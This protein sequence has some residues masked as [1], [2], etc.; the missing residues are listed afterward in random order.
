MS[1]PTGERWLTAVIPALNEEQSIESICKRCLA[2]APRIESETGYRLEVVVV[3]DGST[4]R[5][6]ELARAIDGVKVVSFGYNR[7]YGAALMEGF[8]VGR[9]ELLAFLDADGTCDPK[10]LVP[11]IREV[12]RGAS[13]ALGRR[14]GPDSKMPAVRRLGN[15]IFAFLIRLLSGA[16]VSDPASGM[17]VL[18]RRALEIL[19]P[20]PEG[21]HF[22]PAM[23]CRAA[24]DPRLRLA[25]VEM[26]YAEREGRSKL[27]VLRD[28][29]RFLT[30]IVEIALTYKPLLMLG[31]IGALLLTVGAAY[32][33][34]PLWDFVSTGG[35]AA[36]R[37]YRMLTVLVLI[38]G[39]VAFLYAGAL[40]DL[41]QELVNPPRARSA[42][43][44]SIRRTLFAHPIR[45]ATG[46][47]GLAFLLNALALVQYLTSG[48][49]D[50]PWANIAFGGVLG[51]AGFELLAFAAVQ[52]ML[53]TLHRRAS[54]PSAE[55]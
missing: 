15:H 31:S 8:R 41:A 39:G 37:V 25:E 21:L 16:A 54:P 51:I 33:L 53:L 43:E 38:S 4:D 35:I 29:L 7:G 27:S 1:T 9:G 5:T 45:I 14:L 42:F 26:S 6:A 32:M 44:Q 47:F 22:T 52:W 48:S 50:V 18:H 13:V 28:G 2:E 23:S 3:D 11:M 40:G 36:D 30:V 19:Q 46:C 49:I 34:A 24:L 12:E 10:Y 55:L 17:R 20:L